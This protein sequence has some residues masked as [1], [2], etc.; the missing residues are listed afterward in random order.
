MEFIPRIIFIAELSLNCWRP[1]VLRSIY[2]VITFC[3]KVSG[4]VLLGY[5]AG[6]V[7]VFCSLPTG[8]VR[9]SEG[10][11]IIPIASFLLTI[12][13]SDSADFPNNLEKSF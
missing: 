9:L 10:M 3:I 12:D 11:N 8:T 13:V 1:P 4:L 2:Y 7:P 6:N 5:F